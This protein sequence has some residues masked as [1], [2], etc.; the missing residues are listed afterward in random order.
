MVLAWVWQVCVAYPE[1]VYDEGVMATEA[2]AQAE[3]CV[4]ICV[5]V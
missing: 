3:V 2:Q 1:D 5:Y 4:Y